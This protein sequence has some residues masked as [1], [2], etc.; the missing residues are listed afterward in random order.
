MTGTDEPDRNHAPQP[1]L[2][3]RTLL[4]AKSEYLQAADKLLG[5]AQ[6]ELRIFDPDLSETRLDTP[7][8]I[9]ALRQF[10]A[11]SRL[12]RVYVALHDVEYVKRHCPRL[13]SL[14]G[15][16]AGSMAIRRTEGEG[17]KVQDCF[18]LADRV[19][20]VRRPVARQGRGVF[21]LNDR[22]EGHSMRE[23]FE[24]IW[25][26]SEPGVSANTTGL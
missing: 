14:L 9:E 13:I 23:R 4:T 11:R 18:I 5:M 17:A 22:H 8:R 26:T 12:N 21:I 20:L 1:A 3:E 16:F 15:I 19:N 2:P 24:E 6:L 10:L 7:P 25:E